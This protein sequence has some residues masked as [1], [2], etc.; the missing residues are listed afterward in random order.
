MPSLKIKMYIY[1]VGCKWGSKKVNY[2]SLYIYVQVGFS[3]HTSAAYCP[4]RHFKWCVCL[5]Y[6]KT[7]IHILLFPLQRGKLHEG[8]SCDHRQNDVHYMILIPYFY[9]TIMQ[10]TFAYVCSRLVVY[11]LGCLSVE[12]IKMVQAFSWPYICFAVIASYESLK[13]TGAKT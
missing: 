5:K 9:Q 2:S 13:N 6:S 12:K 7:V 4:F 1:E 11:I 3:G 8:C 10:P